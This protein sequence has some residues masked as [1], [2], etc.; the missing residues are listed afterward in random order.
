MHDDDDKSDDKTI[1]APSPGSESLS[2]TSS[3]SA[4]LLL[5]YD[6]AAAGKRFVLNQHAIV[7]GRRADKADVWVDDASVSREH[8]R[9]T[10]V[11]TKASVTDLG[12]LNHTYVNDRMVLQSS[13][14]SHGDMLRVGN[15]R[16][17]FFAH[18]SADQLLFDKIYKMAVLDR[19]LDIFRK[20]YVVEKLDE[21]FKLSRASG[22]GLCLLVIDLDKFKVIND[23]HGHDAGDMVLKDVC[24]AIKKLVRPT[25]TFGR[26]GGEEFVIILPRTTLDQGF[27]FA[28]VVRQTT[29]RLQIVYNGTQISVTVSIGCAQL[30]AE[31]DEPQDL[32]KL[33]DVMVYRSKSGGRNRVTKP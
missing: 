26:F 8:C 1:V 14:L 25:D 31:M 9:V 20:D 21:E 32:I 4:P 24:S 17:R 15:V 28:E 5:Q 11:G 3:R 10:F 13:E 18:G 19:M 22:S 29:E 12:S 2:A 33:A 16:L 7:I 6:G 30:T 23:T 27:R